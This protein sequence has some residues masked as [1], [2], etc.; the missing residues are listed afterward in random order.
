M[1]LDVTEETNM[2]K[3]RETNIA[4]PVKINSQ[5]NVLSATRIA[6]SISVAATKLTKPNNSSILTESGSAI[7][8]PNYICKRVLDISHLNHAVHR[9]QYQQ[10]NNRTKTHKHF[11]PN[12]HVAKEFHLQF[13]P[14][15]NVSIMVCVKL[16]YLSLYYKICIKTRCLS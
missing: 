16:L 2:A 6:P 10:N 5:I 12:L 7:R 15:T 13:P 3:A 1:G 4:A 11:C 14:L 9:K 8:M